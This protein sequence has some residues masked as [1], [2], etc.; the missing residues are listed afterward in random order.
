MAVNAL[1][2]P[3]T[4]SNASAISWAVRSLRPLEQQVLEEVRRAGHGGALVA[5]A[6]VDPDAERHRAHLGH[7][8]G[9]DPQARGVLGPRDARR[10]RAVLDRVGVTRPGARRSRR[11]R[12]RSRTAA[13]PAAPVAAAIAGRSPSRPR[14]R[15][16][17][18]GAS[19]PSTRGQPPS[20]GSQPSPTGFRL[21][22]PRRVV[23]LLDLDRELVALLHGLLDGGQALAAAR[24]SRCAPGRRGPGRMLTNAPN[25]VVFTTV[26]VEALAHLGHGCGLTICSIISTA[27][28]GAL[29]VARADEHASRRPRCRCRR[30]SGR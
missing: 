4:A 3:P 5:R 23:D 27:F 29:A 22:L 30:R 8:L 24:A 10:R 14:R 17:G 18:A 11:S 20:G 9:D 16:R 6:D 25:V 28:V 2:S 13:G 12:S 1:R 21:I 7:L 15:A 19:S 26:P